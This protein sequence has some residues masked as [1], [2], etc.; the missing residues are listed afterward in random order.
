MDVRGY[1]QML[2]MEW[3]TVYTR[4]DE[5]MIHIIKKSIIYICL[6]GTNH[7]KKKAG[8]REPGSRGTFFPIEN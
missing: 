3:K 7:S 5:Y 2:E 8:S 1:F 6:H 4:V